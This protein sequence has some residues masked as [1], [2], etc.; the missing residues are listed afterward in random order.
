MEKKKYVVQVFVKRAV[1]IQ[2]GVA[3]EAD[4]LEDAVAEVERHLDEPNMAVWDAINNRMWGL[5]WSDEMVVAKDAEEVSD[6]SAAFDLDL[7]EFEEDTNE[8]A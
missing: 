4:S 5:D 7:S 8:A 6:T 2:V 3:V 1:E